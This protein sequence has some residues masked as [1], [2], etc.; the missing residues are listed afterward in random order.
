MKWHELTIRS[1]AEAVE[2]VTNFLHELGAD[3]VSVEESWADRKPSG[4][5]LDEWFDRPPNDIPAG[6]VEIKGWFPEGTDTAS[7]REALRDRIGE[8]RTWGIDPGNFSLEEAVVDEEDWAEAWKR[9]FKPLRVTDR[10][11]IRPI[12]EPYEPGPGEIVIDLDPGMAFGTGTHATTALS[13]KAL[14]RAIRGGEEVIDV[15]TGSGILAIGAAKLGARS[16]LALDLDPVAVASARANAALNGLEDRIDVRESDL[17][18]ALKAG[19]TNDHRPLNVSPPVDVI[20]ANI[21]AE[22]I[23]RFMDDVYAAL[24]PGG[25]YIASGIYVNKEQDVRRGLEAAGFEILDR[26]EREDWIAFTARK[27]EGR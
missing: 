13:L 14:D 23:L 25:L 24:K 6:W 22:I 2:M 9:Y 20:V 15:G 17:L 11:T 3:G 8:L 1:R 4:S 21:L 27:P 10:L 19:G 7:L 16:V 26:D 12:W 5:K 18:G